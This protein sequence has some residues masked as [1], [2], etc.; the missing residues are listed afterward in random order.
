VIYAM[1]CVWIEVKYIGMIWC[2]DLGLYQNVMNEIFMICC[3]LAIFF[4]L[5]LPIW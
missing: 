5:Y 1:R 3:F 4:W 2:D